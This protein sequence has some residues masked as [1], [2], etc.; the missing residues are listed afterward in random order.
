MGVE[1]TQLGKTKWLLG[2]VV[3]QQQLV[4]HCGHLLPSTVED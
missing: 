2:E 3:P 1:T 4:V